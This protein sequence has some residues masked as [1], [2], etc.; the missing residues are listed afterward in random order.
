M[1]MLAWNELLPFGSFRDDRNRRRSILLLEA[2]MT[3]PGASFTGM[4]GKRGSRTKRAYEFCSNGKAISFGKILAPAFASLGGAL[5]TLEGCT[6]L[7]IQD[8]TEINL[9][10]LRAITGLGETG[11]PNDRGF[12]LHCGLASSTDGVCLGLLSAL[13]WVRP[14]EEHGKTADRRQVPFDD[15]E[16]SKWWKTIQIAEGV[17]RRP[18]LLV[19]VGDRECD[20]FEVFARAGAQGYR[21]LTRAAQNRRLPDAEH[22]FL[23]PETESW[24]VAGRRSLAVPARRAR[25]GKPARAA[26]NAE[27]TLRFGQVQIRQPRA[28]GLVSLSAILVR[29]DHPPEDDQIEWLLL[30]NDP[31]AD[32]AAAWTRVEW[33]RRRW[34]IEEFHNCLKTT[35]RA[36]QRQFETQAHYE[37]FLA[38]LMLVSSRI[39]YLR[40]LARVEPDAPAEIALDREEIEVLRAHHNEGSK[41]L[42]PAEIKLRHAVRLIAMIGGFQARKGDGE[43]G[44]KTLA[45]GYSKLRLMIVGYRLALGLPPASEVPDPATAVAHLIRNSPTDA[46][47]LPP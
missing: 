22:A 25:D 33:Y 12:F 11:N 6:V 9:S 39:L 30:S 17:V 26:R 3:A 16:S 1:G 43:P 8:T 15:K 31:L 44:F 32:E 13:S 36:E 4:F 14:P 24:P 23:W 47:S 38:L 40:N 41:T 2:A 42:L 34:L 19:H 45:D 35:G 46:Q 10:H 29:E 7:C 28:D 21:V 5:R 37:N 27:L 20:I 18:G